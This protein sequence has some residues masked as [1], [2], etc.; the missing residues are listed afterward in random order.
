M[1]YLCMEK[2]RIVM[3]HM[4]SNFLS[5]SYFPISIRLVKNECDIKRIKYTI[6]FVYLKTDF[7][8]LCRYKII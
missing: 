6:L 3:N 8:A 4:R 2:I 1:M 5:K 7:T